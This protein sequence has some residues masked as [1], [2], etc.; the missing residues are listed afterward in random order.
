MLRREPLEYFP[1]MNPT[2]IILHHRWRIEKKGTP[3][4]Y[5][6]GTPVKDLNGKPIFCVGTWVSPENL[7]QCRSVIKKRL[8][9]KIMNL[10]TRKQLTC[11]YLYPNAINFSPL[12]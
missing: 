2:S 1:S 6:N 7:E 3:L 10:K 4:T 12:G 5:D 9:H 8:D 11:L